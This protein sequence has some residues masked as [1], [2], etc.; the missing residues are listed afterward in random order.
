MRLRPFAMAVLFAGSLAGWCACT[1]LREGPVD[2]VASPEAS[3]EAGGDSGPM[4]PFSVIQA[5]PAGEDFLAMWGADAQH[6]FVVGTNGVH[7]DYS[8]GSWNRTQ[9]V[10]GRDYF[11]V[12]GT[13]ASDVYAVGI[14]Q[15]GNKG[16]VQ[17][18]D[19]ASWRDEYIA[20]T[21]LYGIWGAGDIVLA[22]G[23]GGMIYGKTAGGVAWAPRLSQG[24]PANPNVDAGPE[25]PILWS[26]AGNNVDNFA[27]AADVDRVFH[28]EG[29]GNF[30]NLDPAVDRTTDF[31]VAWAVPG[32]DTNV[33]FGSNYFGVSWLASAS[34]VPVDLKDAAAGGD[35]LIRLHED[36]SL[37]NASSLFIRGIWGKSP[38]FV[39]V[40]DAGRIYL[41]DAALNAFTPVTS[42]VDMGT[43][44]AGVWG[45][46][47]NDVWI[48]GQRESILHGTLP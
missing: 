8:G 46:S 6:L 45:S 36:Q 33:F 42:P 19:G 16:V 15:A 32:P 14:I 29:N 24:L 44:L 13:S 43:S 2:G 31:L 48:V 23:A 27:M 18:F 28:Y 1:S 10:T 12:W 30:V 25:A 3:T 41:F 7:D 26:I 40:G 22:V 9:V 39:F 35:E 17:H 34:V 38:K 47:A 4:S 11:A 21:A 5:L 20:D 37:P